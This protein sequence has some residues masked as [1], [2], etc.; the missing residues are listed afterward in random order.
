MKFSM[1][2]KYRHS[3]VEWL[4]E[5]PEDWT[6]KPIKNFTRFN[7]GGTPSREKPEYWNGEI[8]W[9]SPKDMK[10]ER[11][12]GAEEHI[13]EKGLA[14]SSGSL[15]PT[16]RLLMVVRSGILQHTIPVAINV[17]PVS[18]NQDIKVF[19]F[20]HA[21]CM[22]DFFL[23]LVQG[24]NDALLLVWAKQGATVESIEHVFLA[25]SSLALPSIEEQS[26]IVDF[27]ERETAKI[28]ALIE[29]QRRL[30]KLLKEKRQAVIS[31]AVTKGFDTSVPMK[32]SKVY[33]GFY[34]PAK[35]HSLKVKYLISKI[36]QG[37]SPQCDTFPA[38]GEEWGVLKVGAVNSGIFD[39]NENKRLPA[40]IEPE[41]SL[42]IRK[43]DV[44][45]SRANTREL[46]GSAAIASNDYPRLLLCDKIYRLELDTR[47]CLPAFLTFYLRTRLIKGVI[48]AEATGASQSM[49]NISQDAIKNVEVSLPTLQEQ[50]LIVATVAARLQTID[51]LSLEA[52]LF[53]QLLQ[54]RRS[55]LI[56]AAVTGKIDVRNYTP[57][58]S[59]FAEEM[60]EPS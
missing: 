24:F 18:V 37:W 46:V 28:D 54:E 26:T 6:I 19:T 29:E 4:G 40:E 8:P 27:L 55:A 14:A 33:K 35:W 25:N 50:V 52:E 3:G 22:P 15:I 20:D 60:Y 17:V 45:V 13:T 58:P 23:R 34:S 56:S 51:A 43:D 10:W 12:S 21:E 1:Y 30:I 47:A 41:T 39:P 49:Q 9:V 38:E 7:G 32:I 42:G 16:G 44:L 59:A 2:P 36:E 5:V 57:Q 31:H 11:I 48:E 53:I